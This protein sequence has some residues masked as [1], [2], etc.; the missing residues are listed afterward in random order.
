MKKSHQKLIIGNWKMNPTTQSAAKRLF[1]EIKKG[2]TRLDNVVVGIAPPSVYLSD[3]AR[4]RSGSK[5]VA[6]CAQNAHWEKTGA[7]TGEIS[8]PMVKDLDVQYVIIGHS[9]RRAKG[10]TDEAVHKTLQAV[11]KSG[12]TA[13]VCVG[14]RRRDAHGNHFSF[15][16]A[17]VRAALSGIPKAKLAHV[18]I[19][20][21][22]I[23]AIGTEATAI[24]ADVH[25][26]KL[27]IQKVLSRLY[28]RSYAY[29]VRILYGGS[30][31]AKN[32]ESLLVE[33]TVKGFLIGGASLKPQE[34]IEI[35]KTAKKHG[36]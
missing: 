16:E 32:A 24:P 18:V 10:V 29:K 30:V 25:E 28:D 2:V 13:I 1:G 3:L 7:H 22:P 5:A 4:I 23:W 35:V 19:A 8:I 26:M 15:V 14:E 21:E 20:Y 11:L 34:F 31:H 36:A 12:L 6:L 9:E 27:F 33:G 17:Q